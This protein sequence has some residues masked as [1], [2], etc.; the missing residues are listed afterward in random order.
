MLCCSTITLYCRSHFISRRW[1]AAKGDMDFVLLSKSIAAFGT[2]QFNDFLLKCVSPPYEFTLFKDGRAIVKG[3]E[4]AS[5]ARSV[6]S[7]FV[8]T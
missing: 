1:H 3:T 8:G 7:K 6:Y 4:E 5:L 2:V